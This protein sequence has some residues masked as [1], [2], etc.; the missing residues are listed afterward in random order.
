M[1][2]V[3]A[4]T[5]EPL[6][7]RQLLV[8]G[9]GV[10][11]LSVARWCAR[12]GVTAVFADSRPAAP[13]ADAIAEL[14]PQAERLS[15]AFPASLPAGTTEV[16]VSPGV[17]LD[18]PILAEAARSGIAA[19]SDIDLFIAECAAPV[20][21]VT[22][23]NGKSTVTSLTA[24]ML[25]AAGVRAVAGGNLGTAALDL[26]GT[27]AEV[28]VLEL[29]SFQL[30]R[31]GIL[32]LH[33]AAILNLTPDHLDQ[34]GD[35]AAYAAAKQRIYGACRR[36]IVNRDAALAAPQPEAGVATTRFG[37]SQP[38][39]ED[40]GVIDTDDGQWIARGSFPVMPIAALP[41]TGRHNVLNVLAAFALAD[42]FDVP[43]DGL[44]AGAQVFPGLPHRMQRVP[45][46]DG[47]VWVND[48]KATNEA[49][50]MASINSID[51]RLVLIAGGDAKNA[52]LKDLARCLEDKDVL[53]IVSLGKDQAVLAAALAKVGLTAKPA[54]DMEEA[55]RTA[56]QY[57][58]PGDTVLLA[59]ACSSL[60]MYANFAARGAAFAAAVGA[61][62][63]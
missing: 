17:P 34:H 59:P 61:L 58:A 14:L 10:T 15:G 51:G 20:L 2:T 55:V 28:I 41:L 1:N 31:S 24:T 45:S 37:L 62:S 50:A 42:T 4:E 5:V 27:D 52:E 32:P 25:Q 9:M 53:A 60:D 8:L 46:D 47:I 23:S 21:G 35:M 44:I 54:A 63:A 26:L 33:A 18:A 22:G 38:S 39:P 48:S 56:A 19:S 6:A 36:A 30:E 49:A 40:W 13:A 12:S 16:I 3:P 43:L 7:E 29:S 11:G 57:A